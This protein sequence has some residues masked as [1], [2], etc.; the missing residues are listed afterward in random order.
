MSFA[1]P[2]LL[3]LLLVALAVWWWRRRRGGSPGARY[4]DVTLAAQAVRRPWW[5]MLPPALPLEFDTID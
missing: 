5:V 3:L 4:S 2:V 1:R